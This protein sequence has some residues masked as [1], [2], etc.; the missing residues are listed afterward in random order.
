M[1]NLSEAGR[2]WENGRLNDHLRDFDVSE[3]RDRAIEA[4]AAELLADDGPDGYAPL[5]EQMVAL[6][7]ENTDLQDVLRDMVPSLIAG[8]Y[9]MAGE[10][11]AMRMRDF[12]QQEA[13]QWAAILVDKEWN[14]PTGAQLDAYDDRERGE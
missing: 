3:A 13:E 14:E 10:L 5:G 12:A 1:K 11:L 7:A 9:A 2:A 4:R 6:F 8:N